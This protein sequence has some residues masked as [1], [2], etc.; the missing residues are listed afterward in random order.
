MLE[1]EYLPDLVA[2]ELPC[3]QA[4]YATVVKTD[5]KEPAGHGFHR[6]VLK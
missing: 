2:E 4:S 3:I 1:L 5:A 6:F